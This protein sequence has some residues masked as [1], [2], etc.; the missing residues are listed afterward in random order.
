LF[1]SAAAIGHT[2]EQARQGDLH[3]LLLL[4]V[5]VSRI[6]SDLFDFS[7]SVVNAACG[8]LCETSASRRVYAAQSTHYR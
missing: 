7:L 6:C 5:A 1:G 8:E 3:F 2:I 4:L